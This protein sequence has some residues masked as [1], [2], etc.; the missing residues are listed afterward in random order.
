MNA[1]GKTIDT[2]SLRLIG[3]TAIYGEIHRDYLAHCLRY[4]HVAKYLGEGRRCK[5]AH[6]LDVGCGRE[7]PL[8]RL[9][10]SMMLTSMTGSYTGVDFG[11]VDWPW[12]N[13]SPEKARVRF[14]QN[15]DFEKARIEPIFNQEKTTNGPEYDLITCF[16]VLEHVEGFHAFK[17]LRRIK[18]LLSPDGVAFLSTPCYS[19]KVGAAKNHVNEMSF[20]AFQALL[21]AAGLVINNVH[22]TFASQRDCK[23]Q[24]TSA[25]ADVFKSLS[26]YYDSSVLAC[27]FAPLYPGLARNCLWNVQRH[28]G[29]YRNGRGGLPGIRPE[30]QTPEHASSE[31]W[32]ADCVAINKLIQGGK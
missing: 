12:P 32:A 19:A 6:I 14:I 17:M 5:T 16:E 31:R 23:S 2:T 24:M 15:A 27:L 11:P 22:G 3:H 7:A 4:S 20:Q 30:L 25:E 13:T 28:P 1:K 9:L 18:T 8:A 26:A 21:S 29:S 10:R